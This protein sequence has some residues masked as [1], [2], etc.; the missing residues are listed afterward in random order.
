MR[1]RGLTVLFVSLLVEA[2][3]QNGR[4]SFHWKGPNDAVV[5]S[6]NI[7]GGENALVAKIPSRTFELDEFIRTTDKLPVKR[8]GRT[9][10]R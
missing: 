2:D 5:A 8:P 9:S 1:A 4:P 6:G 3:A 10:A 7:S